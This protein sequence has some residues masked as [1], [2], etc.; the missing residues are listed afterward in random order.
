MKWQRAVLPLALFAGVIPCAA[1]AQNPSHPRPA[2]DEHVDSIRPG[3]FRPLRLAKWST[4]ALS[5][6]T[7]V[8]GFV[9]SG[10]ADDRYH[11]LERLCQ[12]QPERC[13][14]RTSSGAYADA[15]FESRYAAVRA[16]DRRSHNAL[17]VS[18]VGVA[19]SVVLFLLDLGNARPPRDIPFVPPGTRVEPDA[20]GRLLLG[21]ALPLGNAHGR[22]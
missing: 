22:D 19:G 4:L 1:A 17:L 3:A 10:R 14:S 11:E 6:A 8:Y 12:N 18:Q 9:Q 16:L 15:E 21:M 2:I 5:A 13:A 7:G 20:Q